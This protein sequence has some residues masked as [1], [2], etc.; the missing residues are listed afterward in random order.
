MKFVTLLSAALAAAGI[1]GAAGAQE[2]DPVTL[3]LKWVTQAQFAG[4]YVAE[5]K[6]FYEEAGLDVTIKPGGPDIAPA[7]V[8]A[9]GG[10]DVMVD[11]LP[12][13][14]AAREKGLPLVNIAQPFKSSGMMLTC[15]KDTGITGP[16]DLKG[17]T[18]GVWF[19]GN[20]YPFLSWMSQEGIPTDGG[21]EGVT[22]LKQGFNVDPLLQ[23]QADCISTMTYNEFGQVL[24]AGVT[25]D[26]LVTFKYEDQGVATLEDGLY[27]LEERLQDPAFVDMM[28]RFVRASMKGWEYAAQNPEEA[29][30]IVLE[31]DETGAQTFDHQR[32][33]VEEIGKLLEGSGGAL[34][35]ADFDRTVETLLAGGSDPV[36]TAAP[37]E[38]AWTHEVTDQALN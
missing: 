20:E 29:A 1:A 2:L 16:Q 8:L 15:W 24:D 11:W 9:G 30:E 18:V 27:V 21:P 23:R 38:G 7:Q 14:L 35:P 3:Q 31:N 26:E 19:F 4:Y 32:R 33:M 12:S 5:E 28:A 6:G 10:A 22:V 36:I 37:D 25:E 17:K 34:D 13:A